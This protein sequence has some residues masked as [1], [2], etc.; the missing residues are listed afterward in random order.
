MTVVFTRMPSPVGDVLLAGDGHELSAIWI[1]GQRWAPSIGADWRASAPPF[2]VA[3]R[4][5]DEYFAGER[6]TFKLPLRL[7]GTPFQTE[8][9]A[10]LRRIPFGQ[11]RTYGEIAASLGRPAAA[12]AVGAANGQNRFCI[13]VPCHRLIGAGGGLVDYAAGID[14]KRRL[15]DHEAR[16]AAGATL[17]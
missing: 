15:L 3:R 2:A 10:E 11:T 5:L 14:V 9:W 12:R 17:P 16:V 13:V 7:S 8:V 1:S 6:T 4:Q